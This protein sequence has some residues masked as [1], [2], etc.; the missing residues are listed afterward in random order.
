MNIIRGKL[1]RFLS[2]YHIDEIS[3]VYEDTHPTRRKLLVPFIEP[4]EAYIQRWLEENPDHQNVF[5]VKERFLP[6]M[7]VMSGQSEKES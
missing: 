7:V 5:M 3:R 2:E 6:L 1:E 4:D